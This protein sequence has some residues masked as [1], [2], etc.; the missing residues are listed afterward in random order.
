MANFIKKSIKKFLSKNPKNSI[1]K[2]VFTFLVKKAG[3]VH[4]YTTTKEWL[5]TNNLLEDNYCVVQ[6]KETILL[7]KP[8]TVETKMWEVFNLTSL[9]DY[10]EVFVAKIP[11]GN[12]IS[13]Y[14]SYITK[15]KILLDDLS[16]EFGSPVDKEGFEHS[17]FCRTIPKETYYDK[18]VAIIDTDG[19]YNYFHWIMNILP[20]IDFIE[21]SKME[22]DYYL[23]TMDMPHQKETLEFFNIPPEKIIQNNSKLNIKAKYLIASS[24]PTSPGAINPESLEMLRKK[25][26]IPRSLDK[27]IFITRKNAPQGRRIINEDEVIN[28]VKKYGFE[29]C[30]PEKLNFRSQIELFSSAEII[31][32]P[33]G[34]ALTNMLFCHSDAKIIEIFN[35]KY[36]ALCYW[37]LA[38]LLNLDYYYLL[39]EGEIPSLDQVTYDC[40]GNITV[41]IDK[42]EKTIQL[43]LNN[44]LKTV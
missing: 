43:A 6:P 33:H 36:R 28:L 19:A 35:P 23:I 4:N 14:Y 17:V 1:T 39:G 9:D 26:N 41:D 44:S 15:D 10:K 7:K 12:Y 30:E 25:F 21:K 16:I 5:K 2:N 27:R 42:L 38:N 11:E 3:L 13:K 37:I 22:V 40:S 34:A 20:K 18:T 29:V 32:A 8:K 24:F 31:L